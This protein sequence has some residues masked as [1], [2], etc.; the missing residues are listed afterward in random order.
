ICVADEIIIFDCIE[1]NDRFRCGDVAEDVAFLTMDMDFNGYPHL[2]KSFEK[3][4]LQ[5]SG[6]VDMPQVLNFYRSYYAYVRGKVAS[7]RLTQE[8][9]ETN[10]RQQIIQ[11]AGR[12]FDLAYRY[13]TRLEKPALILTA[14]L[15]GSGKSYQA[16]ILSD[17]L[18]ALIISADKLRKKIFH[19]R[20]RERR[21]EGFGQGIYSSDHSILVYGKI[22]ELAEKNIRQ[23]K[24]VIVD[25]S[26]K[27]REHRI[28][29]R[30]LAVKLGVRFYIL[31]CLCTEET[32]RKRLE[33]RVLDNDSV[34]DGRWELLQSQKKDFAPIDEMPPQNHFII[35]TSAHPDIARRNIIEKIKL[36]E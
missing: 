4:Y 27:K 33:K 18:G 3:F 28:R 23:N 1:F 2:A 7:F 29:A 8:A 14:G 13:A 15:M 26:F 30:E 20:L 11:T 32:A 31:E 5:H 21:H 16:K 9:L 17:Y 10:E 19:V 12:Y 34:S 6:D 35:D 36:D 24:A 22:L 25:A